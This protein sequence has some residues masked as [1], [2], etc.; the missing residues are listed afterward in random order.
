MFCSEHLESIHGGVKARTLDSNKTC[1][2]VVEGHSGVW[3]KI[4]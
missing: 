4:S 1:S 3:S 2:Q